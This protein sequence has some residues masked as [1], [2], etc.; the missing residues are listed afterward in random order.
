MT[1]AKNTTQLP[2]QTT[3][4][5]HDLFN[6]VF[7]GLLNALNLAYL[8]TGQGFDFFWKSTLVYFLADSAFVGEF[9]E[10]GVLCVRVRCV[11]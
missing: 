7:I 4:R 3:V 6:L 11:V 10:E 5:A 9:E 2:T 1:A 8:A